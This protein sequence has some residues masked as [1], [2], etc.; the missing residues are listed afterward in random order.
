MLLLAGLAAFLTA[1]V[2]LLYM[3]M[4]LA[5]SL[6]VLVSAIVIW[7]LIKKRKSWIYFYAV[8]LGVLIALL[9][10]WPR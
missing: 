3:I 2:L 4:W 1:L 10:A 5:V 9:Y 6:V 8:G 7:I